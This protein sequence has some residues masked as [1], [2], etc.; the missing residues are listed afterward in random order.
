LN[1]KD[2]APATTPGGAN[3][4][5]MKSTIQLYAV[6]LCTII[7]FP[8][9]TAFSPPAKFATIAAGASYALYSFAIDKYCKSSE[10]D[11]RYSHSREAAFTE[12]E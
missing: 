8:I 10:T 5:K 4:L 1:K 2:G 7:N 3:H 11:A 6:L 9:C 12:T